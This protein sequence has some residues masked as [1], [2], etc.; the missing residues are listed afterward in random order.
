MLEQIK[1]WFKPQ[2]VLDE[3]SI[4]WIFDTF[5]WAMNHLDKNTFY[6][7]SQL[8]YPNNHFF[9]GQAE[10]VHELAAMI[11]SHVVKHAA[12]QHWP[13]QLRVEAQ[14]RL[15]AMKL[16]YLEGP[17][18]GVKAIDHSSSENRF[19][20]PYL[21]EQV[22]N[23]QALIA[24]FAHTLSGYLLLAA[25]EKPEDIELNFAQLAEVVAVFL[26]FG[27]IMA[28]SAFNYRNITCGSC[29]TPGYDRHSFLSQYDIT[30]ALAVFC[31]LK[32]IPQKQ[33]LAALKPN[34]RSFFK[35]AWKQAGQRLELN[36]LR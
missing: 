25:A 14:C 17:L 26:G 16:P 23:P 33:I 30:Y 8:I 20:V 36:D 19:I 10:D 22:R 29:Y 7:H 1:Q 2:P 28:N 21:P 24:A 4:I 27:I 15:E 32:Q 5:R 11:F 6:Q 9:P 12:M 3:G 34:L 13:L 35:K 18:R 31:H